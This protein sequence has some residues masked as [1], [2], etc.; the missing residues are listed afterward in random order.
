VDERGK[1]AVVWNVGGTP[2]PARWVNNE[3]F[4]EFAGICQLLQD[5]GNEP[6]RLLPVLLK[7]LAIVFGKPLVQHRNTVKTEKRDQINGNQG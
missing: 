5:K 2:I 7:L 3:D 6:L 4:S 1:A